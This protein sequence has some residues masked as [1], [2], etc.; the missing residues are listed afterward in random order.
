MACN[1]RPLPT[2]AAPAYSRI[3]STAIEDTLTARQSVGTSQGNRT[4][5]ATDGSVGGRCNHWRLQG[6]SS[7]ASGR[8]KVVSADVVG[9]RQTAGRSLVSRGFTTAEGAMTQQL[10]FSLEGAAAPAHELL[11]ERQL[12]DL[13]HVSRTTLWRLRADGLPHRQIGRLVRYH[14]GDV[15]AWLAKRLNDSESPAE[16]GVR[17]E[18]PPCHW[19][20]S[21]ALDP[22]HRPQRLDRPASTVRRE[23]WR[24]PQEAHLLDTKGG[25]YRRLRAAEV[26]ALQGFPRDWGTRAG[27][28]ELDLIRGYGNAVPPPLAEIVFATLNEF[29]PQRLA[30]GIEICAGFGGMSLGVSRALGIEHIALIDIWDPAIS[31]LRSVTDW[32]PSSVLRGD[33]RE[34]NWSDFRGKVD[35]IAGGPPCQP[36]SNGGFGLGTADP[37][38]LLAFTPEIVGRVA[39]SAFVFENVPG[40]LSGENEPYARWL[41]ER[42]RRPADGLEYGVAA[43]VLNAADFGVPQ[44]RRRVFI[45]GILGK[46]ISHVH[47]FFDA[48]ARRRTHADPR[49][50][51]PEGRSPWRTVAEAIPDWDKVNDGWRRWFVEPQK[52]DESV[53]ESLTGESEV[54]VQQPV[55]MATANVDTR[56]GAPV[57]GGISLSWPHRGY[58]PAWRD[59]RWT[60]QGPDEQPTTACPL[61][62]HGEIKADPQTDPWYA[63][64]DPIQVLDALTRTLSRRSDLV[65]LDVPRLTTDATD[66]AAEDAQARLDTWLTLG[67]GLFKRSLG[68]L[69]DDGVIVAL[70]GIQELPYVQLLLT[71]LVGAQNHVG[72]VA[73]QKGY[74]PRNMK[75]MKE[76]SPTHDNLVIFARRKESLRPVSL[77][78]PPSDFKCPDNDPRGPW[79][80]EQK[81]ANKPDCDYEVNIPPYRWKIVAGELPQGLWRLNEKSGVIYGRKED[82][83]KATRTE[84]TIE[85]TDS[86]GNTARKKLK[87]EISAN[88]DAPD[89]IAPRWLVANRDKRGNAVAFDYGN[90]E[91]TITTSVLPKGRLGSDYYACLEAM[92][93]KPW[94]GTTRPGK[95]SSDG[96]SRYWD[97]PEHTLKSATT[98]DS[99]DFKSSHDAIPAI[100]KYLQG[101]EHVSLNQ[102]T[103]WLGGGKDKND[104]LRVGYSH[105]AKEELEDL[106]AAKKIRSVIGISKPMGLICRLLA[107]FSREGGSVIDIGSPACEMAAL[108]TALGRRA[109]YVESPTLAAMREDLLLPRLRVASRGEHPVPS[110]VLFSR[111]A[112]PDERLEGYFVG[113]ARRPELANAGVFVVEV[114]RP[115]LALDRTTGDIAIDYASYPTRTTSFAFALAS[116]EGFVPISTPRRAWFASSVDGRTRAAYLESAVFLDDSAT[117]KLVKEH[118]DFLRTGG[119]LRIYYHRG[120]VPETSENVEFRRI[121][122]DL[123][124]AAGLV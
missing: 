70:C 9:A 71:E 102:M 43:G 16:G 14:I 66:F 100:K 5:R 12:M 103:T 101:A 45:V 124:F 32:C 2:I 83:V 49:E 36:W 42:L 60:F 111:E 99:V 81:G 106:H 82:L 26:A 53:A 54:P 48:L 115:A 73:W 59:G 79:N 77:Y 47:A 63:F 35:L 72:T 20:A 84:L 37:R 86:K 30:R 39:P 40:L 122:F 113:G 108:A 65:Y 21:V 95:T 4:P 123:Q 68:L 96:K 92:G 97:F 6:L 117:A 41:I 112:R 114:G 76:L 7:C 24:F 62:P 38:D 105:N 18:L 10:F 80:A 67:E 52:R 29:A 19:R 11:T 61:L 56:A 57:R 85:V 87:I 118:A 44:T 89:A 116:L 58:R 51:I 98:R 17:D 69:S 78:V 3:C 28:G 109:V 33:V 15:Q 13:I 50:V 34:I 121:P 74:S 23:W 8:S 55:Q 31:V 110:G 107:L 64:G 22:K 120:Q 27:L 93:G 25:R 1:D 119:A 91:L 46:P 75:G 104:L 88:A 94:R 90:D